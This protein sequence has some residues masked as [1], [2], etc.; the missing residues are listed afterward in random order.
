MVIS[1]ITPC[2]EP[3]TCP[4]NSMRA[5]PCSTRFSS[6]CRSLAEIVS[7]LNMRQMLVRQRPAVADVDRF[8]RQQCRE[9]VAASRHFEQVQFRASQTALQRQH[10]DVVRQGTGADPAAV[11]AQLD[12]VRLSVDFDVG[13]GLLVVSQAAREARSSNCSS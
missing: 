12:R 13:L 1:V 6:L 2:T 7:R 9:Q 11:F 8:V 5:S 10:G 3:R 4:V